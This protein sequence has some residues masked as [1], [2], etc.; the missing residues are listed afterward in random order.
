LTENVLNFELTSALIKKREDLCSTA[1]DNHIAIPHA[2]VPGINKIYASLSIHKEGI[3]FESIDNKDTNIFILLLHPEN[4]G[5][6]HLKVLRNIAN[7]FSK[8]KVI[9]EILEETESFEIYNIIKKYE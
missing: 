8:K 5:N 3:M 1:L 9:S 2:K 6:E 4:N 7:L